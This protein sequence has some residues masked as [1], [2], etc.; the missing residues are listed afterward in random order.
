M[1]PTTKTATEINDA[2]TVFCLRR[3]PAYDGLTAHW[4]FCQ[5]TYDGGRDWFD[6]NLF[7]YVKEGDAEFKHRVQRAYRFNHTREAVDLVQKYLFKTPV[8]RDREGAPESVSDFW[9]KSTRDGEGIDSL[10]FN[11]ATG[12]AVT[13][14]VA[15]VVDNSKKISG[16]KKIS[17][18]ESK[19][20]EGG[21]Y[22]YVVP[23]A[24]IL[25]YAW[26]EDGHLLWIKLREYHRDDKDPF[27]SSGMVHEYIRLWTREDWQLFKLDMKNGEHSASKIGQG[28]H[29]LG[30]VPVKLCD[31][32][33]SNQNYKVNSLVDD[34]A[35]LDRAVANYLSNLDAIIQDQTFSQLAIPA[36]ALPG[37]KRGARNQMLEIGINRIFTYDA[38]AGSTAKPE[39]I[40]PDPKQAGV[41]LA[42]INK[43][44]AEIYQTIGM[45]G[46]RTKQDNAVGID[47]SSGVAKAYDFERVNSLLLAKAKILEEIENWIVETVLLWV[48]E[49]APIEPLVTYPT[50][51]DVAS[52]ADELVTSEALQKVRAPIEVRREQM[53][54]IVEKLMPQVTQ[55]V[56][57]HLMAAVSKWEDIEL[58]ADKAQID[59]T[60]AS[61][62]AAK[63]TAEGKVSAV[64][65]ST[66]ASGNSKPVAAPNRQGS[67]TASTS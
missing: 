19:S 67:V 13:G 35:Y 57:D 55:E 10:M 63:N 33:V 43:I 4:K 17:V 26:H 20:M 25:D 23:T 5:A 42:V 3:H 22:A 7:K 59:Q 41:I 61:T 9:K 46:E 36:Q 27:L 12:S 15:L 51:F 48:G 66:S 40:S 44:I 11:V 1:K 21:V 52:L 56:W 31:H 14:R 18:R 64:K 45:A 32:A 54:K 38:G 47:N 30:Q 60:I 58:N 24:D 65:P 29:G 8:E 39:F 62:K 53:K 50:T 34:I 49:A 6:N 37:D 2:V 28:Y 16:K